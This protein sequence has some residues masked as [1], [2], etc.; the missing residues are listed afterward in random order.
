MSRIEDAGTLCRM[1]AAFVERVR[2]GDDLRPVYRGCALTIAAGTVAYGAAM[3]L[4]RAPT[5]A[6]FAALKLLGLFAGLF[7]LTVLTNAM[8]GALL[9]T[10]L[11]LKQVAA[12]CMSGLAVTAAILGAL[13]PVAFFV[14]HHVPPPQAEPALAMRVAHSLLTGHVAVFAGAGV[15]GVR[16][17]YGLL[18]ALVDDPRKAT[19][20]LWAWLVVEGLVGAELSWVLRPFLGKPDLE[21][22][23]L[24]ADAF[25]GSF[26]EE[27]GRMT[28]A[29]LGPVG[30]TVALVLAFVAAIAVALSLSA[31]STAAEFSLHPAALHLRLRGSTHA[32]EIPWGEVVGVE[33]LGTSVVVHRADPQSL[34]RDALLLEHATAR[35][36]RE[37]YRA[38]ALARSEGTGGPFRSPA[39]HS[40]AVHSPAV[41][42]PAA[43]VHPP[44]G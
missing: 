41:D 6:G 14:A 33:R 39:V 28:E 15:L 21:V 34:R 37:A 42:N 5:Q 22:A 11:G 20:A 9:R 26:F 24:R 1:D 2:R 36:A 23:L 43:G 35:E 30:P 4:W 40:P 27:V 32:V 29:A 44:A 18:R 19:R 25:D 7:A 12:C 31:A 13:A 8:L 10:G 38:I 17:T 3:G 16:R